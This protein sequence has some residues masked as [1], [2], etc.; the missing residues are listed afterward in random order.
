MS[1]GLAPRDQSL[2]AAPTGAYDIYE[3]KCV[4]LMMLRAFIALASIATVGWLS[5]SAIIWSDGNAHRWLYTSTAIQQEDHSELVAV[6]T[7]LLGLLDTLVA[8]EPDAIL[9]PPD[10][11]LHSLRVINV[12]A[13][14]AAGYSPQAIRLMHS[15][16]YLYDGEFQLGHST[17]FVNYAGMDEMDF[18]EERIM[19][20][21]EDNIMP[22]SAVQL[23]RGESIYGLYRIYD[24]DRSE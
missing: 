19:V 20:Y 18:T 9:Y 4:S 24:T 11:G 3:H 8:I 1:L 22:P 2:L 14:S 12:T 15:L 7:E 23:T 5:L 6:L 21:D 10:N 16:P 13:A 17:H